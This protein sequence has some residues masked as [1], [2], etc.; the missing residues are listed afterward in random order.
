[1]GYAGYRKTL[2]S[3]KE[4]AEMLGLAESTLRHKEAGTEKL[5]RIKHGR[6]TRLVK[7]EVE[8]HIENLI[9]TAKRH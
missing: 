2:I 8:A 3:V 1:M 4:A 6:I 7:Q 9:A 5:T